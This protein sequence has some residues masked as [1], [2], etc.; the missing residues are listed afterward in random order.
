MEEVLFPN[1]KALGKYIQAG[2]IM[3]QVVGVYND[4]EKAMMLRLISHSQ[5]L[6]TYISKVMASVVFHLL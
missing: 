3:W 1:E 4:D 5:L 6:K 2:G